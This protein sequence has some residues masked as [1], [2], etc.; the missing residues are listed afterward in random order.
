MGQKKK[1][2]GRTNK[3][4]LS[5]N[6]FSEKNLQEL[7]EKYLRQEDFTEAIAVFTELCSRNGRDEW[8]QQLARAYQGRIDRLAG[9]GLVKEALVMLDFMGRCCPG[10]QCLDLHLE[11]LLRA[12]KY[13]EAAAFFAQN[14]SG[15]SEE[16]GMRVD[17]MFGALLLAGEEGVAAALGSDSPVVHYFPAAGRALS[18]FCQ[19]NDVEVE[20]A[21]KSIPFRSPYRDFRMLIKGLLLLETDSAAAENFLARIG[22]VSPYW[23]LA[24]MFEVAGGSL[25]GIFSRLKDLSPS[26][27]SYLPLFLG[28]KEQEMNF[29]S[30]LREAAQDPFKLYQV[31]ADHGKCLAPARQNALLLRLLPHCG[32]KME[33]LL[34][35]HRNLPEEQLFRIFALASELDGEGDI[36]VDFWDDVLQC[37]DMARPEN[38]LR[39]ALIL[40]YQAF[41]MR[42]YSDIFYPADILK[43]LEA[44]LQY[45]PDDKNAWLT[46]IKLAELFDGK[47]KNKLAARALEQMPDDV[48]I[49][50][51]AIE[52]AAERSAFKKASS[53]TAHLLTIDPIN[54]RAKELLVET[55]LAHGR[56][57]ALQG[58]FDLAL[59]E[60]SAASPQSRSALYKG[61]SLLCHG[62]LLLCRREDEQGLALIDQGR[63]QAASELSALLLTSLEARLLQVSNAWKKQFDSELRKA[64]GQKKDR[65]EIL[66]LSGW[67]EKFTGHHWVALQECLPCLKKYFA[68]VDALQWLREEG[69]LICQ[70]MC[71]AE[72]ASPLEKLS[73][74]LLK[75]WPDEP[76]FT[77]Y[78][79]WAAI[80]NGKKPGKAERKL[81]ERAAEAAFHRQDYKLLDRIH[82]LFR[83]FPWQ[84]DEMIDED[85]VFVLPGVRRKKKKRQENTG[86]TPRQLNLF[87]ID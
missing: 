52:N 80:R 61:R 43:K 13:V 54:T 73:A 7:G 40:R 23:Q 30:R 83:F 50:I 17:A 56:K 78:R 46:A 67:T 76:E 63:K 55:Q 66:R 39:V 35:R 10:V 19:H 82:D 42:R 38:H 68:G 41:L 16:L 57:L 74:A 75:E 12:A 87:D 18:A 26:M 70:A 15:I 3:T 28:I 62:M 77:F 84:E 34:P 53:L 51:M 65:D 81:L 60:F 22:S 71:R 72:F 85:D 44:S 33:S 31:V 2:K 32:L 9:K 86:P 6:T 45:D 58:K 29:L 47:M 69:L 8:R 36:S 14:R 4:K 24:R 5:L 48:D 25:S 11:L 1:K 37:I 49:L 27:R 59:R 20:Q 64:A 21:L 79:V